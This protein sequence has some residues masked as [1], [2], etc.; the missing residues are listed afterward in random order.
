MEPVRPLTIYPAIDLK[1]GRCVR[2]THGKMESAKTYNAD[3]AAQARLFATAG[4]DRLHIVDLDGAFAGASRN[5]KAVEAI[6]GATG[7]ASQ[8]GGGVRDMRAIEGWLEKGVQRVILGTAA[9]QDPALVKTAAQKFPGRI[10]VGVDALNGEVRTAGWA[11]GSGTSAIDVARRYEDSG[12]AAIIYTDISRDGALGGANVAATAALAR[13]VAIPVIASGGVAGPEDVAALAAASD[14]EG[15][16]VGRAL[17]EGRLD[18][19]A[20]LA[21]AARPVRPLR[22]AS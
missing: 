12:V 16:I 18:A 9:V 2:L 11:G 17:Y 1:D 4:F 20:A 7:A 5:A 6:L 14:I 3:P 19:A 21:A 10:V 22:G 15:V 13:N 8:I